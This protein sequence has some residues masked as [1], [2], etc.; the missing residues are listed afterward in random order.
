MGTFGESLLA[1]REQVITDDQFLDEM[2]SA[3]K[4]LMLVE[5]ALQPF[6]FLLGLC[7]DMKGL[8]AVIPYFLEVSTIVMSYW[9]QFRTL[10]RAPAEGEWRVAVDSLTKES[11]KLFEC[12]TRIPKYVYHTLFNYSVY[13]SAMGTTLVAGQSFRLWTDGDQEGWSVAWSEVPF[14][15]YITGPISQ[16]LSV[17]VLLTFFCGVH[18]MFLAEAIW[19]MTHTKKPKWYQPLCMQFGPVDGY[20]RDR[21]DTGNVPLFSAAFGELQ[22]VGSLH[23]NRYV[24]L[25]VIAGPHVWLKTTLLSLS[26]K[27]SSVSEKFNMMLPISL[28]M[29]TKMCSLAELNYDMFV[30]WSFWRVFLSKI[31]SNSLFVSFVLFFYQTPAFWML[32]CGVRLVGIFTCNSH[33]LNITSG[34]VKE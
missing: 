26:W 14:L 23:L 1:P 31:S 17:P 6:L 25:C 15:G 13:W 24:H 3:A 30:H 7:V 33:Y 11:K 21:M 10:K 2:R 22:R 27:R 9:F 12:D 28:N 34:C 4:T 29:A 8:W 16:F 20:F 19:A 18:Y 5:A 32:A